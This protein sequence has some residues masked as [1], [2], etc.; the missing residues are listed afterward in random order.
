MQITKPTIKG[1]VFD[2]YGTL[3]N[4]ASIDQHLRLLF[5]EDTASQI[6]ATWRRK[7]LEYTW[8]RSLMQ[9]YKDFY[10]LTEEALRYAL[11]AAKVPV[12]EKSVRLLMSQYYH[13]KVYPDVPT[14]LKLLAGRC[15]LAILSNANPSLL[16]KAAAYN[17]ID[18]LLD[19]IISVDEL[20]CYKPDPRVYELATTTLQLPAEQILFLSSNTWDIAGAK[21]LGLTTCWV[22]RN[23]GQLEELGYEPN[24]VVESLEEIVVGLSPDSA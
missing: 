3:F 4:V 12:G 19:H 17:A 21:A 5:G 23:R 15:P 11:I 18:H 8:L 1:I 9:Q 6:A 20:A 14:V 22:N 10:A 24:W 7:Q 13:L 2:A 16:E